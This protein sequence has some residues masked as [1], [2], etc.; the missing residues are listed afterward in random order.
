MKS[1][2]K[3]YTTLPFNNA[4]LQNLFRFLK[5]K[6]VTKQKLPTLKMLLRVRMKWDHL[7]YSHIPLVYFGI[8]ENLRVR[9]MYID[10]VTK[11]LKDFGFKVKVE[12][13]NYSVKDWINIKDSFVRCWYQLRL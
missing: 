9:T 7:L 11:F 2:L 10:K 8:Q 3:D 5:A 1:G 12:A 6:I 13:D 4:L